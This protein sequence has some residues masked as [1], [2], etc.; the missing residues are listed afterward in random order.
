MP[1]AGADSEGPVWRDFTPSLPG[2]CKV[3]ARKRRQW[4][5]ELE[6]AQKGPCCKCPDQSRILGTWAAREK[7]L[8]HPYHRGPCIASPES[9]VTE[10][11]QP[12]LPPAS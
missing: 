11:C 1:V 12:A 5:L 8:L 6:V 9:K 10:L 3:G 4:P 7:R 2:T